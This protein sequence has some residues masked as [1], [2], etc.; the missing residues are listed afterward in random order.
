MFECMKMSKYNFNTYNEEGD[1]ILYNFLIGIPSLTKVKKADINIFKRLFLNDTD[2]LKASCEKYSEAVEHLL[3][4]GI[5]VA[6]DCNENILHESQQYSKIYDSRMILFILPTGNCNF[7]CPYCFENSQP[8][9]GNAMTAEIQ[10]AIVKFVQRQI[11]KHTALHICWFGGEPLLEPQ[12]IKYLS[13]KFIQICKTRFIPCSAE[14]VTNGFC[15]DMEMFKLLYS[16]KIYNFTITLDGFKEQHDK[17]RF[18]KNKRGSFDTIIDNLIKIRN[19]KQFKYAHIRIRVNMTRRLIDVLDDFIDFL[20]KTFSE[21]TR[22]SFQFMPVENFS[23]SKFSD[24]N[25]LANSGELFRHLKENETYMNRLRSETDKID[26]IISDTGCAANL[27][28]AYVIT[29]DLKVHKCYAHYDM[30]FNN[31]G[32]ISSNGELMVNEVLHKRWYVLNNY[33]QKIPEKCNDCF[34]LPTCH[35]GGRVCPVRYLAE[36]PDEMDCLME[37]DGCQNSI[38]EAVLYIADK[39][40]CPSIVL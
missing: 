25:I 28:N 13:E 26:S 33:I 11:S 23:G 16:L 40:P 17:T 34:Y 14:I 32:F 39:Y 19:N 8:F 5:L 20:D 9:L 30:S 6:N 31:I 18:L 15:L 4:S 2:I 37:K 38:I 29:P 7:G 22:F 3:K 10:N 21:D 35:Y 27:K 36:E 24:D 1:L 12:I